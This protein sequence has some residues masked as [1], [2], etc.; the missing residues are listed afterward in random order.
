MQ[1]RKKLRNNTDN[2]N[3]LSLVSSQKMSIKFHSNYR[4]FRNGHAFL[5]VI[6]SDE[7]HR[8]DICNVVNGERV[9][10]VH[11]HVYMSHL[12]TFKRYNNTRPYVGTHVKWAL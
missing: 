12:Y 3:T 7:I 10:H 8:I 5:I 6:A 9:L 2:Y 1:K 4:Q 11:I